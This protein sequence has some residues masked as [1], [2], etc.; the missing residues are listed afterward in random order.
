MSISAVAGS[1]TY[2]VP[3]TAKAQISDEKTESNTVKAKEAE[4]GKDSP[5]PVPKTAASADAVTGAAAS[6]SP[7]VDVKA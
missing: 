7:S 3:I 1:A 5:A 6:S 4:T 2:Q